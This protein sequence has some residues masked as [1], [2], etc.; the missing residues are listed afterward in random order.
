M[1]C[2]DEDKITDILAILMAESRNDLVEYIKKLIELCDLDYEEECVIE[3]SD[4]SEGE[5]ED[6]SIKVDNRGFHSLT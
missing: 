5:Y 1:D 3:S 2:V 4:E 6:I